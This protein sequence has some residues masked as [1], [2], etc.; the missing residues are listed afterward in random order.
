MC[1]VLQFPVKGRK[2]ADLTVT[3]IGKV[4][5]T[6]TERGYTYDPERIDR[7]IKFI[8]LANARTKEIMQND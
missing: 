8:K 6:N 2:Q 1:K 7:M 4:V 3:A 5:A